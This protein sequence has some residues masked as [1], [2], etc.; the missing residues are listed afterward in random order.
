MQTMQAT[1]PRKQ[2]RTSFYSFLRWLLSPTSVLQITADEEWKESLIATLH[3]KFLSCCEDFCNTAYQ[4]TPGY[5]CEIDPTSRTFQR[6]LCF[7]MV[8]HNSP[9]RSGHVALDLQCLHVTQLKSPARS[10][11]IY[12]VPSIT[13]RGT[14][15][16]YI[17]TLDT[18][19]PCEHSWHREWSR[20]TGL[21]PPCP[22]ITVNWLL[23]RPPVYSSLTLTYLIFLLDW[24][25][26]SSTFSRF[27]PVSQQRKE[28]QSQA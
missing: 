20:S 21:F 1:V 8:K 22:T 7:S 6:F 10:P 16:I 12:K 3:R 19:R 28:V 23:F 11:H 26:V 18:P 2:I 13:K 25:D 24:A 5:T 14:L 9:L 27:C 4:L 17:C 15:I